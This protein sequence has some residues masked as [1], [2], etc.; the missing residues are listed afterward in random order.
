MLRAKVRGFHRFMLNMLWIVG[1]GGTLVQGIQAS[2]FQEPFGR[3]VPMYG[4][5]GVTVVGF[6][7]GVLNLFIEDSQ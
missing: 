3:M 6:V 5:L 4:L 1:F 7:W 2:F